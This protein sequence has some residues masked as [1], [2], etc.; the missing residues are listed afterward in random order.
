MLLEV[1]PEEDCVFYYSDGFDSSW[2]VFIDGKEDKIYRA[3]MAF[4]A[5][6]L[7]KGAH[8]VRLTYDPRFYKITLFLYFA[9]LLLAAAMLLWRSL[10]R[11][12]VK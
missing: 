11:K 2:R 1:D 5:V 12:G 6:M 3:N 7:E 10:F 8:I 4:K 9:G